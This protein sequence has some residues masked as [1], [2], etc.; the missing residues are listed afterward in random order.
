MVITDESIGTFQLL[1][2]GARARTDPQNLRHWMYSMKRTRLSYTLVVCCRWER[3]VWIERLSH[4]YKLLILELYIYKEANGRK[5]STVLPSLGSTTVMRRTR[6]S[7][8]LLRSLRLSWRPYWTASVCANK[9]DFTT[10]TWR[11]CHRCIHS[12][13]VK[14]TTRKNNL[15]TWDPAKHYFII[16]ISM[17]MRLIIYP[18]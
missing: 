9:S 10:T 12:A 14:L 18:M 7:R 16:L 1:V 17:S 15:H 3:I 6:Q 13:S 5:L 2:A 4:I 8:D 11:Q